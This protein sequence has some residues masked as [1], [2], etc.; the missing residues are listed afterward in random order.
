M[1]MDN[2]DEMHK[3]LSLARFPEFSRGNNFN[4]LIKSADLAY[5]HKHY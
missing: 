2:F 3:V 4:Q 5:Y 1:I